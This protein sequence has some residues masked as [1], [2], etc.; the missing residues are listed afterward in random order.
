MMF[1]M[2]PAFAW[3][4]LGPSEATP[5]D[6]TEAHSESPSSAEPARSGAVPQSVIY[7]D[8]SK[9]PADAIARFVARYPGYQVIALKPIP[10]GHGYF[11]PL[12]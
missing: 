2:D 4:T 12:A 11:R 9:V 3:K 10:M 5:A 1:R 8:A 7:V 6:P